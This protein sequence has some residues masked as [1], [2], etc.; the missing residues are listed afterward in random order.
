MAQLITITHTPPN[1]TP[2]YTDGLFFTV[3]TITRY[4]KF[5]FVYDIVI[6][7][8]I[9]FSG[10]ATPNPFGLGITDV[11]RIL[12]NYVSN[13]P[14]SYMNQTPI[15]THE[16]FPFSRPL[17]DNVIPYSIRFGYEY[18]ADEISPVTGFTGNGEFVFNPATGQF[19]LDGIP[20]P[21]AISTGVYKTFQ[22]TMG[23]NGRATQQDFNMSPFVL[24]GTPVGVNPTT[25]NLFLTNSPRI[26]D[27]Q[28]T[29]YYTLGFT[30]YYLDNT[31]L[32][33]PYYVEYKFYN[34]NGGLIDTRQYQNIRSNGGG[35]MTNCDYVYQNYFPIVGKDNTDFNTLYVG[36]GPENIPD[37]P[38][39]TVQYTI[40]LFGGYVGPT[41]TLPL[42]SPTPTP[43]PTPS[44]IPC[45]GCRSYIISNL[46]AS[47]GSF[48]Y[49]DCLSKV[50][51]TGTVPP[52]V[53][54]LEP[55][56]ACE[57]SVNALSEGLIITE[58]GVCGP[59]P[60]GT[61][62]TITISNPYEGTA[63][64]YY[65]DCNTNS[66]TEESLPSGTAD[67]YCACD[68]IISDTELDVT[69]GEACLSPL[70]SPT[71]TPSCA[72]NTFLIS[73]C[74]SS[75]CIDDVCRCNTSTQTTVYAACSVSNPFQ[76]GITLY[77]NTSLTNGFNGS[78]TNG[79]VVYDAVNGVVS[80]N[81][82][83]LGP[84]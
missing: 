24:T 46:S 1:F 16:T 12:K 42:P 36:A 21:P 27:I 40:Q 18:A 69:I 61:C 11:S 45:D 50:I 54:L 6:N 33:E 58:S 73:T 23:V 66:W 29:E 63:T 78:Y 59:K 20:G 52:G 47:F 43:T 70:P 79:S 39:D 49:R 31:T 17:Y 72:F 8:E 83:L 5:R 22:S 30:N 65:F 38:E 15:Y 19:D 75:T 13:L 64:F 2:V 56:C 48:Q 55:I 14:L 10:K 35:P 74:I 77:T 51:L 82:V 3:T 71:P 28:P 60:C 41:P 44:Q 68:E 81:C 57:G 67:Q 9:I 26:R 7:N 53:S 80:F 32:S 62:Y 25:S 34:E 76:T 37:F 84:C 4:P